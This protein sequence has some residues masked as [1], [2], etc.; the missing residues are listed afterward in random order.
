M[1]YTPPRPPPSQ[2]QS[3]ALPGGPRSP[4]PPR[5]VTTATGGGSNG[6]NGNTDPE[7]PT[8]ATILA[9]FDVPGN[10]SG[11]GQHVEFA[12]NEHIPLEEGM[13][14][15]RGASADV[16]EVVCRGV[17]IAR[18]Q[19]FC[20]RRMKIEDVKRELDILRKLDHKH[21]VTLLGSYTQRMVLGILLFPAAVCDL[22]VYL[23]ELDEDLRSG[24]SE[25]GEAMSKIC[26][27]LGI[28]ANLY[29]ARERLNRI[30]GCLAHAVQYLHDN[31]VRHKDLK[32]RNI[33]L[34]RND[35]IFVTD[36][37][38]SR[39]TTD[40]ST[41]VTNGIERGTYKYCAPEVARYEPRGRA[42]DIYS[43]GC[44]FLEI[45]TVHRKLS[46]VEFDTFRTK[47]EDH[48]F[49][50]SPE[51]LKEWM[52][53]LRAV[54]T[55]ND[56]GVFDL[57]D[58]VE[59]MV[60]E[61]PTDRPVIAKVIATL[62]T[63]GGDIYFASC[64]S[65][66]PTIDKEFRDLL[67]KY[68]KVKMYYFEKVAE[69]EKLEAALQDERTKVQEIRIAKAAD[70][71][72]LEAA[73]EEERMKVQD[74][75]EEILALK[76]SAKTTSLNSMVEYGISP[77]F[78]GNV[79]YEAIYPSDPLADDIFRSLDEGS[80]SKGY[81]TRSDT[82]AFFGTRLSA[83]NIE[84]IWNLADVDSNGRLTREEFDIAMRFIPPGHRDTAVHLD[85]PEILPSELVPPSMRK[86]HQPVPGYQT[87]IRR[88]KTKKWIESKT[89]DY[90]GDD[91]GDDD[92]Y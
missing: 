54:P 55:S 20:S 86:S 62:K 49:Q 10:W 48:S 42:A 8:G 14:L 57:M 34:D 91:W 80:G 87:N 1:P 24:N 82:V 52:N 61:S 26:E 76:D 13:S 77:V 60:A 31:D 51:Q 66:P 3:P 29:H 58:L 30:Y 84:Q 23:D 69:T 65:V 11:K 43:L 89:V 79:S 44:V 53:R 83:Y 88:Q 12:R 5:L 73:L 85:L 39:D 92:D 67:T 18:K 50:N 25:L 64:C 21:V 40:A 70:T 45:N 27:R 81:L 74:M 36:F 16:H 90:G 17:K 41:S 68:R 22:G 75:A 35:G 4:P 56:Q 71:E 32:P 37:G 15:G 38:L 59:K 78:G 7:K 9:L 72:R 6:T 19:I 28:P 47:N 46:L 63:L 33:L 2:A